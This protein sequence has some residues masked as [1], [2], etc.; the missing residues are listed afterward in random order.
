MVSRVSDAETA[1]SVVAAPPKVGGGP[2]GCQRALL[3]PSPPG[4]AEDHQLKGGA[5]NDAEPVKRAPRTRRS[6]RAA[7]GPRSSPPRHPR[8]A[9]T[10]SRTLFRQVEQGDSAWMD[11]AERTAPASRLERSGHSAFI[12][13]NTLF[14]FGGY[15]VSRLTCAGA[16]PASIH[17]LL[18][19]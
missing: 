13:D 15:Q 7:A 8:S 5:R 18:L 1:L 4:E 9:F 16:P 10:S 11:S 3:A 14:V 2:R 19:P 12:D 6:R 17:C